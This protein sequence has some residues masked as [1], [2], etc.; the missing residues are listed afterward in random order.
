MTTHAPLSGRQGPLW[1]CLV[2]PLNNPKKEGDREQRSFSSTAGRSV[3]CPRSQETEPREA[4]RPLLPNPSAPE[5]GA[6]AHWPGAEG[7]AQGKDKSQTDPAHWRD[8]PTHQRDAASVSLCGELL[9]NNSRPLTL[10][11]QRAN[12]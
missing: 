4:A 10:L 11:L 12:R 7:Q 3:T 2:E 8:V 1:N 6:G 9:I 5:L